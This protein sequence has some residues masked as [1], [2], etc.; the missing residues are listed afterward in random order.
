[1]E[2]KRSE[3]AMYRSVLLFAFLI[4]LIVS[5]LSLSITK[6]RNGRPSDN[7]RTGVNQATGKEY[8]VFG[9]TLE[10]SH[11]R[12][13][14]ATLY[15]EKS[16]DTLRMYRLEAVTFPIQSD[17]E[18]IVGFAKENS[19]QA[20]SDV[21]VCKLQE[22]DKKIDCPEAGDE[23]RKILSE[24]ANRIYIRQY[25]L[26]SNEQMYKWTSDTEFLVRCTSEPTTRHDK[27]KLDT[28]SRVS[29]FLF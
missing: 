16:N 7:A 13:Y 12:V 5:A 4:P 8:A 27:S 21:R 1:M 9:A 6:Y 20:W 22:L 2:Y 14:R 19:F 24:L 25:F 28:L 10:A 29:I 18:K 3:K 26:N 17:V 15:A 23:Y 11:K